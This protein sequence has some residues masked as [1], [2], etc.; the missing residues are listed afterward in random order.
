MKVGIYQSNLY[1]HPQSEQHLLIK[2]YYKNVYILFSSKST[3]FSKIRLSAKI[4]HQALILSAAFL[5]TS[6]ELFS[7]IEGLVERSISQ[8]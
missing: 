4:L 5:V 2:F 7:N 6:Q 8:I 3:T 1:T